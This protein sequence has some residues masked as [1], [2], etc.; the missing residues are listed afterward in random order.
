MA[1]TGYGTPGTIRARNGCVSTVFLLI[2]VGVGAWGVVT[3][4]NGN[5]SWRALVCAAIGVGCLVTLVTG[6]KIPVWYCN[7]CGKQTDPNFPTCAFC[8]SAKTQT[9][10]P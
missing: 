8:G 7:F 3:I 5:L 4:F 10:T 9:T 2:G 1:K 6:Q